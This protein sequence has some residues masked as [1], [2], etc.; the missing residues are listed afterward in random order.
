MKIGLAT[1]VVALLIN[2]YIVNSALI[3]L[4]S[5]PTI[6]STYTRSNN[7]IKNVSTSPKI[8]PEMREILID[9]LKYTD[10]EVNIMDPDVAVIVIEKQLKRP[11]NGMPRSWN[12]LNYGRKNVLVD[13]KNVIPGLNMLDSQGMQD[14]S[15][16]FLFFGYG[17]GTGPAG[18]DGGE[19]HMSGLSPSD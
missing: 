14:L 11:V 12:K 7:N 3:K 5:V 10:K 6:A 2:V 4:R 13:L 9:S 16:T 18:G 19:R 17:I 1:K 8:T 15:N